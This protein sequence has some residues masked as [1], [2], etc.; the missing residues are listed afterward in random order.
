MIRIST[1]PDV[2]WRNDAIQFPR[3]ISELLATSALNATVIEEL[4][5]S[6]DVSVEQLNDILDRADTAWNDIKERT[7][8]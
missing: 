4:A 2:N 1:D 7:P 3:L 5:V 6:M 8:R